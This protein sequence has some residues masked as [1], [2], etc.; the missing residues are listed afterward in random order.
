MNYTCVNSFIIVG[1]CSYLYLYC[2][3]YL[4]FVLVVLFGFFFF[5]FVGEVEK[6]IERKEV[7]K[8]K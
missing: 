2:I 6:G 8:W 3:F 7:N 1:C 5:L 4:I